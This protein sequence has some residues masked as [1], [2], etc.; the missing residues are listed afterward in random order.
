MHA[1]EAPL[2]FDAAVRALHGVQESLQVRQTACSLDAHAA[3]Y[4]CA[5]PQL[6]APP[7]CTPVALVH[8]CGAASGWWPEYIVAGMAYCGARNRKLHAQAK[9]PPFAARSLASRS[10]TILICTG[11]IFLY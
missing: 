8:Q 7:T 10:N 11:L 3:G 6:P 9:V 5:L 4:G 1:A 2:D